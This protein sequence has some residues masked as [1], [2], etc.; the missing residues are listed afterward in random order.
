MNTEDIFD[1]N[2]KLEQQSTAETLAKVG[3]FKDKDTSEKNVRLTASQ[4]RE[5]E[6]L[7]ES[8]EVTLK[9]L[10]AKYGKHIDTFSTHFRKLGIKR[11]SKAE[12]LRRVAE[13]VAKQQ[14]RD[15]ASI[16]SERIKDTK[17]QH[18]KMADAIGRLVFKEILD[19]RNKPGGKFREI[20]SDMQALFVA[21]DTLKKVREERWAILGLDKDVVDQ[22]SLPELVMSTMTPE[23]AQALRNAQDEDDDL[24]GIDD[25]NLEMTNG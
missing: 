22:D 21:M 2:K 7:W 4:W 20:K 11:G 14:A 8:G 9:D 13:E 16:I 23:Q 10:S 24:M 15:E 19:V 25:N 1:E 6:M 12:E 18:Y 3:A 5:I 17:E